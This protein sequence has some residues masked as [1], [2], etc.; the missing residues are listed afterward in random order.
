MTIGNIP[1]TVAGFEK[2]LRQLKSNAHVH[3]YLKNIPLQTLAHIFKTSEVTAELLAPVLQAFSEHGLSSSNCKHTAEFLLTWSKT[4]NF[5]M[6]LMFIDDSERKILAD[7]GASLKKDH[8]D[9]HEKY[10]AAFASA[11]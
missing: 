6:T 3:E 4:S 10:Y 8:K 1:K 9:L 11:M 7:V 2:D 5:E